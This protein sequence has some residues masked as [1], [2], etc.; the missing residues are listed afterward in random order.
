MAN[1]ADLRKLGASLVLNASADE[2]SNWGPSL[3]SDD[4]LSHLGAMAEQEAAFLKGKVAMDA[5]LVGTWEGSTSHELGG[6]HQRIEFKNDCLNAEVG[7]GWKITTK[8]I[9]VKCGKLIIINHPQ[10]HQRYP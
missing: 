4:A 8:Q 5:R 10:K 9:V 1:L 3:V 6:Y 2:A 7:T